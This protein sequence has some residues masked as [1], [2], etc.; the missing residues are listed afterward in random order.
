[1]SSDGAAASA[2]TSELQDSQTQAPIT[3]PADVSHEPDITPSDITENG[4]GNT[5]GGEDGKDVAQENGAMEEQHESGD[6]AGSNEE[7]HHEFIFEDN[8]DLKRVKVYELVGSRWVDQGT[9]FC[10]PYQEGPSEEAYLI[11]RSEADPQTLILQTSIRASDV[12]QR[13]QDTLIVWTEPDGVDYALSFQDPDG[14]L[15][16]WNF[17]VTRQR[18]M[19]AGGTED[20]Q[21][22]SSPNIGPEPSTPNGISTAAIVRA[23]RLPPPALGVISEIERAIKS[24]ART[25]HLKERMCEHIQ[26]EGYIKHL[27]DVFNQAE[28]LESLDNLHA[29]CTLMQTI[30]LLNDHT[31][32]EHV[33]DDDVFFGVVGML[34]YDPEFPTYKANY[35]E[36]L[37]QT[38][39]FHQP[40]PIRDEVIQRKIHQTYRL[41]FLKDVVLARAIDDSTFNVLNSCIIFNQ[42]DIITHVQSDQAF[43]KEIVEIFEESDVGSGKKPETMDKE[44]GKDAEKPADGD[45][46][47]DAMDV[48]EPQKSSNGSAQP[49]GH[50]VPNGDA[51]S[52][53]PERSESHR[54][55][56]VL[57]VQQLCAMGKNVQ[58]PA[59]MA[60][61]RTLVDRGLL[62]AVQW[63]FSH[64]EKTEEGRQMIAAGGEILSAML[65]HDTNGVRGYMVRRQIQITG[66]TGKEKPAT[67]AAPET[68]LSLMCRVLSQS[69]D[70]AVQ[71]QIGDSLKLLL[72]IPPDGGLDAPAVSALGI[73]MLTRKDDP[74]TEIFLDYFYK[75][76]ID[77]LFK[78][79]TDLPDYKNVT[80]PT[81]GL[82]REKSNLFLYLCDLLSSFALQH[83]FRSHFYI[84]SSNIASR[85]ASLLGTRDK[86]LRL[87]AFRF[88]RALLKLNN[89]NMN[90]HLI[91]LDILKP[92]LDLTVRE[93]RRDN[94][95]SC[96]CQ[97]FFEHMRRENMKDL[98]H[99]CMTTHQATIKK[100]S[101]SGLGTARFKALIRRYEM[102]IEP[103]PIEPSKPEATP[104]RRSIWGQGR[105]LEAEEES[106]FNT[107]DD[108]EEM[109]LL[110][111][112]FPRAQST[113]PPGGIRRK[114]LRGGP[115]MR[116]VR[117]PNPTPLR[118]PS[119]ALGSL[120]DYE[121]EDEPP[122]G[123]MEASTSQLPSS[124]PKPSPISQ[125]F[126][127]D[128]VPPSPTLSHRQIPAKVFKPME[129]DEDETDRELEALLSKSASSVP[130]SPASLE[131]L[132]PKRRREDDEDDGLMERLASKAV[133]RPNVGVEEEKS[134]RATEPKQSDEA[135]RKIKLK[136]GA[137]SLAV[138]SASPSP[139]PSELSAKDG[140]T[141]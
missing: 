90:A 6:A 113:P 47:E 52:R 83:S 14:C 74:S 17:I 82:T 44:D 94:L 114:R 4:T 89:R 29:L 117:P 140:D 26:Q 122:N 112:P 61:F 135:P 98:I 128:E 10:S 7:G 64:S 97:E 41:Q 87:A 95:I 21:M 46:P 1:M 57:L 137:T 54:R 12:Y 123:S 127:G 8:Y 38:T 48:D 67:P 92:I 109:T 39:R 115:A 70:L 134:G 131:P 11:A 73:K 37:G 126:S 72:E 76:C 3:L 106:Y 62:L 24:L 32:Y 103:P 63:A 108:E 80:D 96:S 116:P 27:V 23:G 68:L 125:P 107:D 84:L 56:V 85:V 15:E 119:P 16:V 53:P 111:S 77:T 136:F 33:L 19:N 93:S 138:A 69:R 31:M 121:D 34:E 86:H 25:A 110:T 35:R 45:K 49:N 43:L 55:E 2:V 60:L 130:S 100:L 132:T 99:H 40:I 141:G 18:E 5:A 75:Q 42:I 88:F 102:N 78:S 13:Q 104:E 20:Q 105:L 36:F 101:E 71:S 79:L 30:L 59:R 129:E 28:D 133:K 50:T 139:V 58:L 81:L 22:T 120:L 9:A 124:S 51:R 91:K 65:D 118:S 66:E